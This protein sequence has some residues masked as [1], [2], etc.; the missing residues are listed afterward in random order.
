VICAALTTTSGCPLSTAESTAK[1]AASSSKGTSSVA[2]KTGRPPSG[3]SVVSSRGGVRRRVSM[4]VRVELPARCSVCRTPVP[5]SPER[6]EEEEPDRHHERNE[7][8]ES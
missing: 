6:E 8:D 3:R 5:A 7:R 4:L 1:T 2:S